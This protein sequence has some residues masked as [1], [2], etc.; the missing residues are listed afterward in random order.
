MK[1]GVGLDYL[2]QVWLGHFQNISYMNMLQ[3]HFILLLN[4]RYGSSSFYDRLNQRMITIICEYFTRSQQIIRQRV[5]LADPTQYSH[6]LE[7]NNIRFGCGP[8]LLH[9]G[10]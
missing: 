10:L 1:Q 9:L 8:T 4:G 2:F 5:S 6:E 3:Y 7:A